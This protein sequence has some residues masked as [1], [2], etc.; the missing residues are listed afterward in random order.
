M[1]KFVENNGRFEISKKE[2]REKSR[3]KEGERGGHQRI[4]KEDEREKSI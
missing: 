4:E 1:I 3:Q 2:D